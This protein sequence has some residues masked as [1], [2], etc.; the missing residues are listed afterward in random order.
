MRLVGG[1]ALQ[2]LRCLAELE[3]EAESV[4]AVNG[5]IGIEVKDE[6][7]LVEAE[8]VAENVVGAEIADSADGRV[9]AVFSVAIQVVV[10]S[11]AAG[12]GSG[13]RRRR[14]CRSGRN[15]RLYWNGWRIGV[16]QL[17]RGRREVCSRM[18]VTALGHGGRRL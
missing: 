16:A 7:S 1:I 5:E 12:E 13:K 17:C 4:A 10:E 14:R 6:I 18:R 3:I 11:G 8:G 15:P 2:R 9:E